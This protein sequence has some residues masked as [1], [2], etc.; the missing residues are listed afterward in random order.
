MS[1]NLPSTKRFFSED[2]KNS[3]DWFQRFLGQ[4]NLFTE[5]IYNLLNAGIDVNAN[6]TEE[7]YILSI[8]IASATGT[9][10]AVTFFPK[11][12]SGTPHG[13]LLGQC[14]YNTTTGIPAAVDCRFSW[15]W[16]GS[17]VRILAIYGLAAGASY[18]LS[19][20]IY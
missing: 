7:I 5:P 4:L 14:L 8:P 3:A 1:L 20:R 6:T 19:L 15:V 9:S 12:F 2:Y 11:K 10:N 18:T 17:Q 13:V 16:T